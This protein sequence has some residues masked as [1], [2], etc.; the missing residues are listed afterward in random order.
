MSQPEKPPLRQSR[1]DR[2]WIVLREI[3]RGAFVGYLWALPVAVCFPGLIAWDI[4]RRNALG[5]GMQAWLDLLLLGCAI[6]AWGMVMGG[7]LGLNRGLNQ[8]VS[9]HSAEVIER[10]AQGPILKAALLSLPLSLVA[11]VATWGYGQRMAV[12]AAAAAFGICIGLAAIIGLVRGLRQASLS[13]KEKTEA[14]IAVARS[15][16][17]DERLERWDKGEAKGTA[18]EQVQSADR[19]RVTET[20]KPAPPATLADRVGWEE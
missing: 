18:R 3:G 7:A 5:P 13:W 20:G 10:Q 17:C 9:D 1:G 2:A 12:A 8:T 16:W 15:E 4:W 11:F 14:G 6:C 19:D